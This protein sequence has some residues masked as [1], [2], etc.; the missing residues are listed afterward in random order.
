MPDGQPQYATRGDAIRAIVLSKL[1]LSF[2]RFALVFE[3]ANA[4][5][6][7]AALPVYAKHCFHRTILVVIR[8][9]ENVI[10]AI[11]FMYLPEAVAIR[12]PSLYDHW[13]ADPRLFGAVPLATTFVIIP[14]WIGIFIGSGRSN[15][16]QPQLDV[17]PAV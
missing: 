14:T 16:Y 17:E 2:L 11:L 3:V 4:N 13:L 7:N 1:P 12:D 5:P 8:I 9:L 15:S 10:L 6:E